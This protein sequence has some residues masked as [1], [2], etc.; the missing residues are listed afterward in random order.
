MFEATL[1]DPNAFNV[2]LYTGIDTAPDGLFGAAEMAYDLRSGKPMRPL[3]ARKRVLIGR[4]VDEEQFAS[5]LPRIAEQTGD[6]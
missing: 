4:E 1:K 3:K 6:I 2:G 5:L